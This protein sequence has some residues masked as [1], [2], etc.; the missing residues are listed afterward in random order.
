MRR[1]PN[2]AAVAFTAALALA[3]GCARPA[4]A[5]SDLGATCDEAVSSRSFCL[6]VAQAAE[7]ALPRLGV[8]AAAGSPVQGTASTLGMRLT[9]APRWTAGVRLTTAPLGLPAVAQNGPSDAVGGAVMAVSADFGVGLLQGRSPLPTVGG[10]GSLDLLASV[11]LLPL[12]GGDGYLES[13]PWT[14]SA[15]VRVGLLRESFTL[16]GAAVSLSFRRLENLTLGDEELSRVESYVS[17]AVNLWSARA[18]LTKT[19]VLLRLTG[20]V[21]YDRSS[22]ELDLGFR[23]TLG[24]H[25]VDSDDW[26]MERITGFGSV[27][28]T[29]MVLHFTIEGGWQEGPPAVQDLPADADPGTG[30]AW[31][32]SLSVRLSI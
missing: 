5:Q 7:T 8:A 22:G 28:Y 31:Y 16:P 2:G 6:L 25:T 9:S 24:E 26:T 12:L 11:G 21:G 13:T 1:R 27:S 19:F 3:V 4:V 17:G 14:W 23:D 15:G 20:G 29:L 32:G 18:A 10:V 30:A